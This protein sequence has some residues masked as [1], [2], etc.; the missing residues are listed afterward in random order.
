MLAVLKTAQPGILQ[1]SRKGLPTM[2]LGT[3]RIGRIGGVNFRISPSLFV[4]AVLL[5]VL[6]APRL[7]PPGESGYL[8]AAGFVIA[9]YLS[10]LIHE[11]AH[12]FAALRYQMRVESVILHIMGGQTNIRGDSRTPGQEFW[13]SIVGPFAT[14]GVAI[15][16]WLIAQITLPPTST[17]A[18]LVTAVNVLI[19]LVNLLPGFPLDGG[20]VF[21]AVVWQLTGNQNTGG[22]WAAWAGRVLAIAVIVIPSALLLLDRGPALHRLD[23]IV[24]VIIAVFLWSGASASLQ[25]A[26]R[27]RAL[28]ALSARSL[29]EPIKPGDEFLPNLPIELSG[30]Q[31]LDA[32]A[33]DSGARYA[34]RDRT[35][36]LVGA[37]T[38]DRVARA[39]RKGAS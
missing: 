5:I 9:L 6:F 37:L 13:I 15:F 28:E 25:E 7:A 22:I 16:A 26:H 10:V 34:L 18:S 4:A 2:L 20:R 33:A 32:M 24:A 11:L 12:L 21:S 36:Q 30:S 3:W 38:S 8:H 29:A 19:G 1:M 23:L 14:F 35:G 27:Q 17:V 39:Y 31:L